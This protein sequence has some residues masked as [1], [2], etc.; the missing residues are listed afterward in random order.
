MPHGAVRSS[1]LLCRRRC[2]C[3]RCRPCLPGFSEARTATGTALLKNY[4]EKP[5]KRVCSRDSQVQ[6]QQPVERARR[7]SFCPQASVCE[8]LLSSLFSSLPSQAPR[9]SR[10]SLLLLRSLFL[11]RLP[12][13]CRLLSPCSLCLPALV[14]VCACARVLLAVSGESQFLIASRVGRQGK[15]R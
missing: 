12:T 2:R 10:R 3:R 4:S 6:R 11:H 9:F 5:S 1:A 15:A 13:S 7:R 8:S 14:S